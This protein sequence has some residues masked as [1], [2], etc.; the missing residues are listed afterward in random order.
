MTDIQI[1]GPQRSLQH[2]IEFPKW[3][4]TPRVVAE[5]NGLIQ[6]SRVEV[7][8]TAAWLVPPRCWKPSECQARLQS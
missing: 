4:I 7:H 8:V 5:A 2:G 1:A 6:I 3:P